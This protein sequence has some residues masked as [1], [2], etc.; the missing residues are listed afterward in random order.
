MDAVDSFDD[1]DS[2][3]N[4]GLKRDKSR[5]QMSSTCSSENEYNSG[6]ISSSSDEEGD[7]DDNV[8]F[9]P[10]EIK[11]LNE[12]NI[13]EIRQWVVKNRISLSQLDDLLEILRARLLATLTKTAKIFLKTVDARYKIVEMEDANGGF[14]EFRYFGIESGLLECVN[15]DL[16]KDKVI[17]LQFNVDPVPLTQ[18]GTQQFTPI[19]CK[20]HYDPDIYQVFPVAIYH[21]KAKVKNPEIFLEKFVEEMNKLQTEGMIVENE[22]FSVRLKCF[23]CDTPAG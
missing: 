13:E 3:N 22:N 14:G 18:S 20:V 1:V 5:A 9:L 2:L 10:K 6:S 16:Y 4:D 8:L 12:G 23:I 19:L 17:E 21:K 15:V 7:L 11:D